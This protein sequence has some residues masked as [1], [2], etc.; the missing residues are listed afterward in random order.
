[1]EGFPTLDELTEH[2]SFQRLPANRQAVA[3]MDYKDRAFRHMVSNNL[4]SGNEQELQ[5]AHNFLDKTVRSYMPSGNSFSALGGAISVNP[6][7]EIVSEFA[8]AIST[9]K[10]AAK[11]KE[12]DRRLR[13]TQ[14]P[15]GAYLGEAPKM[16][17]S[18]ENRDELVKKAGGVFEEI[19]QGAEAVI[20]EDK[21]RIGNSLIQQESGALSLSGLGSAANRMGTD[22]LAATAS[23]VVAPGVG[24]FA[25]YANA[26]IARSDR[27]Q[28]ISQ[29]ERSAEERQGRSAAVGIVSGSVDAVGFGWMTGTSRIAKAQKVLNNSI[30]GKIA[31]AAIAE[32]TTEFVQSLVES[33]GHNAEAF[34]DVVTI[35]SDPK[36]LKQALEEAAMGSILGAGVRGGVEVTPK[37]VESITKTDTY[38]DA[39]NKLEAIKENVSIDR[40][41]KE[42]IYDLSKRLNEMTAETIAADEVATSKQLDNDFAQEKIQEV[43]SLQTGKFDSENIQSPEVAGI[44]EKDLATRKEAKEQGGE[45]IPSMREMAEEKIGRITSDPALMKINNIDDQASLATYLFRSGLFDEIE[46]EIKAVS[47]GNADYD[48]I[49]SKAINRQFNKPEESF[50]IDNDVIQDPETVSQETVQAEKPKAQKVKVDQPVEPT[51]KEVPAPKEKPMSL[52][53]R[54]ESQIRDVLSNDE[55]VR[56]FRI[57]DRD[58]LVE[59]LFLSDKFDQITDDLIDNTKDSNVDIELIMNK[60]INRQLKEFGKRKESKAQKDFEDVYGDIE[61][62][63]AYDSTKPE[64]EPHAALLERAK[65]ENRREKLELRKARAKARKKK[66]E[67]A[68]KDPEFRGKLD[69]TVSKVRQLILGN[70]GI[71]RDS[72]HKDSIQTDKVQ[73]FSAVFNAERGKGLNLDQHMEVLKEEGLISDNTTPEQVVDMLQEDIKEINKTQTSRPSLELLQEQNK[74][75]KFKV[76]EWEPDASFFT[77]SGL[78]SVSSDQDFSPGSELIP[79]RDPIPVP[80]SV[81]NDSS[82]RKRTTRKIRDIIKVVQDELGIPVRKG[83]F[84]GGR[85]TLGIY[86][87]RAKV[88]RTRIAE[89]LQVIAHEV[90]HSLSDR[91][92]IAT[93]ED[94]RFDNELIPIGKETSGKDYSLEQVREEGRAEFFRRMLIDPAAS[95]KIAPKFYSEFNSLVDSS[96]GLRSKVEKVTDFYSDIT[97][98][99]ASERV[100]SKIVNK[101]DLETNES[102][103]E[104]SRHSK[105]TLIDKFSPLKEIE[106]EVYGDKEISILKSP[107]RMSR[108]GAG[109]ADV[110]NRK[111]ER[112]LLPILKNMSSDELRSFEAYLV[113]LRTKVDLNDRGIS[114][115]VNI[116]EANQNIQEAEADYPHFRKLQKDLVKFTDQMLVD[117]VEGGVLTESEAHLMKS[118]NRAYIPLSRAYEG[119]KSGATGSKVNPF[120]KIVGDNTSIISPIATLEENVYM[121]ER[122]IAQQKVHSALRD[123]AK[124][125]GKGRIIEKVDSFGK[126]EPIITI[127]HNGKRE[128]F[129]VKDQLVFDSLTHSPI[130]AS[131]ITGGWEGL[132]LNIASKAAKTVNKTAI[133]TSAFIAKNPVRDTF[134]AAVQ[135]KNDFMPVI[136]SIKGLM[137]VITKDKYFDMFMDSGGSQSN[138]VNQVDDIKLGRIN[139]SRA[140]KIIKSLNPINHLQTVA[141]YTEVATRLGDFR[142]TYK[143]MRDQGASDTESIAQAVYEAREVT[144]DFQKSGTL[145]KSANQY[146]PFLNANI[147]GK[148]KLIQTMKQPKHIMK[149][150]LYVIMPEVIIWALNKDDEDYKELPDHEK[151]NFWII[152]I[153]VGD[154]PYMR[155]PK[156]QGYSWFSNRLRNTLDSISGNEKASIDKMS[157]RLVSDLGDEVESLMPALIKPM[158]E[159]STNYSFF[160]GDNIINKYL[161]KLPLDKQHNS[162][163]S[164]VSK[165]VGPKIGISPI[166]LDH[167]IYGYT[168]NWGSVAT[169]AID[170]AFLRDVNEVPAPE[171]ELGRSLIPKLTG[172]NTFLGRNPNY[173]A[174]SIQEVFEK[175]DKING[176]ESLYRSR[177]LK[178]RE[179]LIR[180]YKDLWN[181][182]RKIKIASSQIK[183]LGKK[184]NSI[185]RDKDMSPY[186]K[187]VELRDTFDKMIIAA[188]R[189]ISD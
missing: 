188:R 164:E 180:D 79:N 60:A 18:I 12:F 88:I 26:G 80:F 131:I 184:V 70:G 2:E 16:E 178:E 93:S 137:S 132:A 108:I 83:K 139:E 128:F 40:K 19:R 44:S 118:K 146:V 177:N 120:K 49:I 171:K 127:V 69:D 17:L 62:E 37:A 153:S 28:R 104:K 170:K 4:I 136:D 25:Y 117:A 163:T 125:A 147:Q 52:R 189:G 154:S 165:F 169:S 31:G 96:P 148:T 14:L 67:I 78:P 20:S 86:K 38:R 114:S 179:E 81:D 65:E 102:F 76:D 158:I 149:F 185:Y 103:S 90:G 183:R 129:R 64:F 7:Q 92:G 94:S 33:V 112:G 59:Y 124:V 150:G 1:M 173:S 15:A 51:K 8:G 9:H 135:S 123:M 74:D 66:K 58:S 181:N 39:V 50:A 23:N 107:Y 53:D 75:T 68:G 57:D 174:A 98:Q 157:S 143:R 138:F 11:N 47:D 55:L 141:E 156:P 61:N 6:G 155:I 106:N 186:K 43:E 116:Q 3:L 99:T 36:V 63:I 85:K 27:S 22:L 29:P 175:S 145:I 142:K 5:E 182:R 105:R 166:Y 133:I 115:G 100:E 35:L 24:P 122:A 119:K 152:P 151:N 109:V 172:M 71:K 167:L 168:T 82:E 73:N 72:F 30:G 89:D 45:Y 121:L 41:G 95:K 42:S 130:S 187:K 160:R 13:G 140:K 54:A 161:E 176:L 101:D 110:A 97:A 21:D 134:A 91:L 144:L 32:G 48:A 56:D 84:S 126:D 34:D 77:E 111:V 87:P 159:V 10:Q 113:S 46:A 162:Y